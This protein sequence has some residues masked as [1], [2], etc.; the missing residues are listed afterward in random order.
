VTRLVRH[1]FVPAAAPLAVTGLYFTP[2]SLFGC[3]NR[4]L[5]AMAVVLISALAACVTTAKGAR[6][7]RQ[8]RASANWWL[9]STLILVTPVVLVLGP[10]G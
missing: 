7:R 5:L 4:G 2:V 9:L 1:V 8:G 3:V 6:A 10:L